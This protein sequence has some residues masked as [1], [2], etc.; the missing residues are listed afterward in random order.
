MV[1]SLRPA[2]IDVIAAQLA[3]AERQPG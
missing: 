3:H 2:G 1:A